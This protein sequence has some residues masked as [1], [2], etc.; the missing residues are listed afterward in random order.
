V[1][2]S[3]HDEGVAYVAFDNH[4]SD[5]F[6]IYL[7]TT[8]NYGDTWTRITN[9][10]P[11]EAGTIHVVREDPS[12]RNLLFAGTEFGLFVSFD[13]GSNWQRMKNGFPTVPVD[14]IQIHPREH[15]LILATHG[16][17]LWIFDDITPLE[18]MTDNVLASDLH[19]FDMRSAI[20][21]HLANNKG[22]TGAREFLAPNPPYG[23]IVDYFLKAKL[24]GKDPVKITVTD[25]SGAKIREINGAAESGINRVAWDLR[26]EAPARPAEPPGNRAG[27]AGAAPGA[28]GAA[29]A[30]AAGGGEGFGFGGGRGPLVDP[31]DYTITVTAGGKSES[32]TVAVEE[33]PRL[34]LSA[35]DRTQRHEA[36]TKLYSMAKQADEGRREIVAIRTSLTALTDGWKR[37]TAP[38]IPD[39][40]KKAAD[41][42]LAKIKAVV[43]TFETER[44]GQ[45]GSAGPPL[46]YTPPPV[47][48][49]IGRLMFSLDSYSGSPTAR[50]LEDIRQ[51]AEELEPALATVKKLV[52]EDLPRLNKMMAD[53]GIPYVSGPGPRPAN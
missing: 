50:Q 14:D 20:T 2:A 30:A 53:A 11:E 7:Y 4:R 29:G 3:P 38:K 18:E 24:E 5:D 41:D 9:G 8:S 49:K 25:K 1:V 32:K 10:I 26:Y 28:A 37:P 35:E 44:E 47:N 42:L 31:G 34:T 21:W 46:K 23:A 17:S 48:Q 51:A 43:G 16:R 22:N 12:N 45:L 6:S 40:V 15:D 19:L 27:E 36:L 33:D 13:R 52:N 39:D